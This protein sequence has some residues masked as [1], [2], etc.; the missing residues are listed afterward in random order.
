MRRFQRRRFIEK[1][2]SGQTSTNLQFSCLVLPLSLSIRTY[3]CNYIHVFRDITRSCRVN[4]HVMPIR[5]LG[6]FAE[7]VRQSN[8]S[9]KQNPGP[10]ITVTDKHTTSATDFFSVRSGQGHLLSRPHHL[11]THNFKLQPCDSH[12]GLSSET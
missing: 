2:P 8:S 5:R 9:R 4:L 10:F 11:I 7:Q 6:T 3:I 12:T 1:A